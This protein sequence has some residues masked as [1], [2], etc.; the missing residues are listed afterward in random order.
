[1]TS[2]RKRFNKNQNGWGMQLTL[3]PL[4]L[5]LERGSRSVC[6]LLQL[7]DRGVPLLKL[8]LAPSSSARASWS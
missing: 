6:I 1:M 2:P 7:E 4:L 8:D 3:G 5:T